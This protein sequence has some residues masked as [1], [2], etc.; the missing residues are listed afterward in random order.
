MNGVLCIPKAQ[1][2]LENATDHLKKVGITPI[3]KEI[4]AHM[5]LR[6]TR[7]GVTFALIDG[8]GTWLG[9]PK[10]MSAETPKKSFGFFSNRETNQNRANI[11]YPSSSSEET[12]PRKTACGNA[13]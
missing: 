5:F 11:K 4:A 13:P 7:I 8:I 3:S 6:M 9:K 10:K 1:S 2:L 12:K